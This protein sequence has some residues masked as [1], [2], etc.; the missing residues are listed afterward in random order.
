[1]VSTTCSKRVY[2]TTVVYSEARGIGATHRL[3]CEAHW[4]IAYP[5]ALV[6]SL[7]TV[8]L[9]IKSYDGTFLE[10]ANRVNSHNLT[11]LE[12]RFTQETPILAL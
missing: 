1:M 7:I 8:V 6:G 10:S 5:V 12:H 9:S 4:A 3:S 2:H 11:F